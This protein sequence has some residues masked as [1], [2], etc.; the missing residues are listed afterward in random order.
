[1]PDHASP[2]GTRRFQANAEARVAPGH[3]RE[4]LGLRLSSIGM[5]TYLGEPDAQTDRRYVESVL[6]YFH[7]GGNVLDT[8]VNYRFQRSERAI[9]EAL[10]RAFADGKFQREEIFV[11]TKGGYLAYDGAFPA[12]PGDY[13]H[14]RFEEPGIADFDDLVA[15]CHCMT[16]AFL[17]DSLETSLSNL[18]LSC[19]DLY[20]L[21][22]PED[23]LAEVEPPEL[24]RRIAAAF[25]ELEKGVAEGKI[26]AY[27]VATWKGLRVPPGDPSHLSLEDL[28][29]AAREAGGSRHH[30]RAVQAP[31]SLVTPEAAVEPTQKVGRETLPVLRAA[32]K[33][34]LAFFA[35]APFGQGK[36]ARETPAW[37]VETFPDL[38]T[39]AQRALQFVRSTPGVDVALAGMSRVSHV[40][41][42]LRIAATAPLDAEAGREALARVS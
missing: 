13:F 24:A 19:V 34:G 35:S 5:G 28:V 40:D 8:A 27:G 14:K 39:S 17:R 4:A 11:A 33:L 30:F 21:H 16:P 12:D 3:F 9:G 10:R 41:E 29:A 32:H 7:R 22:N 42:N 36:L 38:K 1:L 25:A 23:Q 2:E 26:R 20:L 15:G 6:A 37:L 18:G 31:F